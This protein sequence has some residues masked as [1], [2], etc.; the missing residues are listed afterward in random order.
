M[1]K[2][3]LFMAAFALVFCGYLGLKLAGV[4]AQSLT[5]YTLYQH[6]TSLNPETGVEKTM[7]FRVTAFSSAGSRMVKF[8]D[9]PWNFDQRWITTVDGVSKETWDDAKVVSSVRTPQPGPV[10]NPADPSKGCLTNKADGKPLWVGFVATSDATIAGISVKVI[11]QVIGGKSYT[12]SLAPSL[13][14]VPFATSSEYQ[15]DATAILYTDRVDLSEPD[16]AA[17]KVDS[18][19]SELPYST[20]LLKHLALTGRGDPALLRDTMSKQ[21]ADRDVVYAAHRP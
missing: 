9:V 2:T 1:R 3:I 20:A 18:D 14:C 6:Q 19:Y 15:H 5:P 17:F 21:M 4:H 16:Q 7:N 8:H 12:R 13:D 10:L 11:K